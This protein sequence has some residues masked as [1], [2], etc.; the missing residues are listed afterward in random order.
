ML[1]MQAQENGVALDEEQLLFIAGG[2]DND[3]D[4]DV[5]EQPI[6]DLALN[7]DDVFQVDDCDAL[8]YDVDEAPL[9]QTMFMANLSSA[10]PIY[11]EAN[12][13]YDSDILSEVHDHDHYHD[14]VV[15][16]Y[17][18][19]KD[20]AVP[21]VQSN[22]SSI[23]NDA[24]MMIL[25]DMHEQPAQHVFVTIQNSVV[26]KSLTAKVAAYKEQV[27][28]YERRARF[29]L[30]KREQKIDEQLRIVIID[31]NIKEVTS[32]KKDFKQKENKY[33]EEFLDM[34]A[35]KEKAKAA[36]PVRDLMVYPPN[37][38]VK[39]V[40]R[41]LPTKSQCMR[42][43]SSSILPGEYS[44][45]PTS[46]NPKRRNRR[47]SKQP[48]I[49]EE[50]PV[51]TMADQHTMA[52]LLR[53]PTEGYAEAIVVP[54]ILAEQFELKHSL[55]NMITSDQFFRLEKDNPHDHIR[56]FNK[57]TFTIKYKDVPNSTIKLM[58]FPFSLAGA[59]HRSLKK[60]PLRS[61]LTW[62]D[63][64]SK[65]INEFFPSSRT[66]N[67]RNEISNFQQWFDESFHEAWDRYKDLRHACPHHGFTELHQLDTFYNALNPADQD[68]LNYAAGGNLLERRL[69]PLL[70]NTIANPKGKLKAITTRS[71]LILDVHSVPMPSL[72]INPKEDERV[73]ETLMDLDLAEYT[74]KVPPPLV[75]KPKP[76]SQRIYVVHQMDHLH[77]NIPYPSRMH[78]QLKQDKDEIQI[79]KF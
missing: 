32:L 25:I 42:T 29:E 7:V 8:D 18:Y 60:E 31:H 34:K 56:W 41:V 66:A 49:L 57:I 70:S 67:L 14:A 73:E 53:A 61:I 58:L 50:S 5:D 48:F 62:E 24:Y 79:H 13:S 39:L 76:P 51:D 35:L 71:G 6:Q 74:I 47:R 64:V 55:I 65:F 3:V 1:L 20:N 52:E 44:P 10:D 36:K 2:K 16:H 75:Q 17:E 37:T 68:S 38:P 11:D 15:E 59:S 77:P 19:V 54:P 9:V 43:R 23:P 33:L 27:K 72:F 78:K 22:V 26:D 4:E 30:T 21:V 28:V 12:P 45:I 63:L 40:P 46:S 69:G